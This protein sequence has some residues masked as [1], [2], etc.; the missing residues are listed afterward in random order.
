MGSRKKSG[1][2]DAAITK[3]WYQLGAWVSQWV[4]ICEIRGLSTARFGLR[5]KRQDS[6]SN[7]FSLPAARPHA[8]VRFFAFTAPVAPL[9]MRGRQI[10]SMM[11]GNHTVQREGG[12]YALLKPWETSRPCLVRVI[13]KLIIFSVFIDAHENPS[14]K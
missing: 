11:L 14:Y 4:V 10:R 13:G 7:Y 5:S 2:I 6:A 8:S 9:I 1:L 12:Y 3:W